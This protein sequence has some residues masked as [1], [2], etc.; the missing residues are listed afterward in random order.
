MSPSFIKYAHVA[1]TSARERLHE[2]AALVG[3]LGFLCI[4]L[5]IFSEL[6]NT[7]G[8][9]SSLGGRRQ[10][11][12]VWYVAVT[13]W[14]M[15]SLPPLHLEVEA[16]VRTGRVATL[17]PQPI[18]YVGFV[19]AKGFGE[20]LVRLATLGPTAFLLAWWLT[21]K[22][23]PSGFALLGVLPFGLVAA[24][25]LLASYVALGLSAFWLTDANP[26]YM[27]WQKL[28][29]VCGGMFVPLDVY[30]RWLQDVSAFTPFPSLLYG[31]ARLALGGGDFSAWSSLALRLCLWG[32][33]LVATL[34]FVHRRALRALEVG[35][36]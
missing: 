20:L 2:R 16:H 22:G 25:L 32:F 8:A 33:V 31:P 12:F 28:A 1:L 18:S 15:L 9:T 35:G 17:L 36:G 13:E 27:V 6:W 11:D 14:I 29:F 30:P 7:I 26:A 10:T 19:F 24:S 21:G 34:A 3:R 4:V 5:L 23:P